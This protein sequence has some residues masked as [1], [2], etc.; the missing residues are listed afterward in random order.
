MRRLRASGVPPCQHGQELLD[1]AALVGGVA[2]RDRIFDTVL[3]MVLEDLVLH[4]PECR[5]HRPDLGEDVDTVAILLDH[6]RDPAHLALDPLQPV[7]A[8]L[9]RVC[10]HSLVPYPPWVYLVSAEALSRR[11]MRL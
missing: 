7:A 11:G 9:L 10:S 2:A 3:D 8:A 6:A 4:A 5:P 1:L